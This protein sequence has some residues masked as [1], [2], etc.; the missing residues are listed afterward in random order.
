[1]TCMERKFVLMGSLLQ[2]IYFV[3][4]ADSCGKGTLNFWHG[5]YRSNN[6]DI[7]RGSVLRVVGCTYFSLGQWLTGDDDDDR[8][9]AILDDGDA[10]DAKGV[11]V[12]VLTSA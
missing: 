8:Q 11:M 9:S 7:M 3:A 1:M 12:D 5:E 6:G 4:R 2:H 10:D